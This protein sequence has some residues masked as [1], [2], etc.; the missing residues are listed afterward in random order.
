MENKIISVTAVTDNFPDGQKITAA[1]IQYSCDVSSC[2]HPED[3]RVEGR[4]II[5]TRVEG[6]TLILELGP[7][8]EKASLIPPPPKPPKGAGGPPP[9]KKGPPN[10]PPAVRRPVEVT[11]VADGVAYKSDR[12]I[13]PVVEAFQQF[14]L[15]GMKY[16][17]YIPE[18]EEGKTYPLVLYIHDAGACGADVKIALSQ[19]YGAI[20]FAEESWQKEHPCFVLAPQVDKGPHGPM[21]NDEF[22]V[23]DDFLRVKQ[24]LDYVLECY[25]V[26]RKRVYTTGQS[27][28]CMASCEFNIRYPDLFAAS[29]LVAGQWSPERMAESCPNNKLWILVSQNDEKAFPGMNAVTAAMEKAGAKIGRY[30]WNGKASPEELTALAYEVMKDNVNVHYTV[31]TDSSV[32]PEGE[33]PHSGANHVN[34][35]RVAYHILG[36]KEWLFSNSK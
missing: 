1:R 15:N 4:T 30:R 25:P 10:L 17:L 2:V 18:I 21:T 13:E 34:T 14:E 32:V 6:N 7:R 22:E 12:S 35:W 28:G 31:F 9:G 27:M 16:N 11:V 8:D 24:I 36:L 3:L 20:G 19:G 33:V 23:T 26:D 5:A 29:L